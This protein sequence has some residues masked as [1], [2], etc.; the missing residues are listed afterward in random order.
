MHIDVTESLSDVAPGEWDALV[1]DDHPFLRHAFLSALERTGCVGG[2]SGWEPQFL[3]ARRGDKLVGAVPLYLKQHSYGEYVFD[4]A[5]ASAHERMGLAYYPKLVVAA[6]FTPA[7]G[8]RLLIGDTP[9]ADSVADALIDATESQA[10]R[11][12]ASSVHWLFTSRTDCMRLENRGLMTRL[13][14]QFHWHN[15]GYRTFDDF[16]A[17]FAADK[18]KK[19]KRER[20][21]V[22]EAGVEMEI[23]T[24][25]E[26]SGDHWDTF[27]AFYLATAEKH[28][29]I[30]YL[31]RSFFHALGRGLGRQVVLVL[32]R[33]GQHYVA[34]A[35]NL[36]GKETLY[37]RYWGTLADYHS[38]H[39]ETCY[40]QAIEYCIAQGLSRFEAGAQ[41][42]HKIARG[43]LP[44]TTY[45]AHWLRDATLRRAVADFLARERRGMVADMDGLGSHSPF[46]HPAS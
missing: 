28:G 1:G 29:A 26:A 18:R 22:R 17:G 27:Y 12:A 7:T 46:K 13:G 37:G 25:A 20:R 42:E 24:G 5:W 44:A 32:A 21:Y 6:P 31:N 38:L 2:D 39:F 9:D 36:R 41:G 15:R 4:W 45:S 19:V 40:Y 14:C 11:L 8:S 30:P 16:L 10:Q 35:L 3:L 43:F 23:V 34:G 33:A